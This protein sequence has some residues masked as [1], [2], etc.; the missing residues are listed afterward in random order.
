MCGISIVNHKYRYSTGCY[1]LCGVVITLLLV[2]LLIGVFLALLF[3]LLTSML[4]E[5]SSGDEFRVI[6]TLFSADM[7]VGDAPRGATE[8]GGLGERTLGMEGRMNSLS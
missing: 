4:L 3:C 2:C 8:A 6:K 5:G 7:L 1:M